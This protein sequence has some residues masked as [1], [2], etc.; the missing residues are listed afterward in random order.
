MGDFGFAR[1]VTDS[2]LCD[3]H[4]GSAGYLAPEVAYGDTG[5]DGKLADIW[6]IGVILFAIMTKEMPFDSRDY[7]LIS[8]KKSVVV[9]FP[10]ARGVLVS[11]KLRALI[12]Q[13]LMYEPTERINLIEV[14]QSPWIKDFTQRRE[15]NRESIPDTDSIT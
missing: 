2:D 4:C 11:G 14:D 12:G 7:A 13:F 6:S 9:K 3:T 15:S 8:R 5:Y 10:N 1:Y